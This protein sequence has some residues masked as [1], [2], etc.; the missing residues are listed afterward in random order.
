MTALPV[1]E[2]HQTVL[3]MTSHT[4][5]CSKFSS[6]SS[7][8]LCHAT[9]GKCSLWGATEKTLV[10]TTTC[11]SSIGANSIKCNHGAASAGHALAAAV[12]LSKRVPTTHTAFFRPFSIRT[13]M[14]ARLQKQT[15]RPRPHPI[16]MRFCLHFWG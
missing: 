8:S 5:I 6:F 15:C 9:T 11:C 10:L 2:R 1:G 14:R 16:Q 12:L 13:T 3:I 7:I 4:P